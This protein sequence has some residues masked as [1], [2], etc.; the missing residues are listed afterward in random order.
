MGSDGYKNGKPDI[1][2]WLKEIRLG[3]EYR[4]RCAFEQKWERW[5]QYYRGEW[6][7]NILP[8]NV[9]FKMI[10]STV[11]RIYFRNPS[12]SVVPAMPGVENAIF[13]KLLERTDNKLLRIMKTKKHMKRM[14]Q[15]AWMFGTGI[16]KKGFGSQ[17]QSTPE[18]FG[19][20]FPM[21]AASINAKLANHVE[22]NYDIEPNMPW[23]FRTK[24]SHFI[25][26][27]GIDYA[28]EARW[29]CFVIERPLADIKA[30]PTK[31][32]APVTRIDLC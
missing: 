22:Y 7:D 17:Y 28:E 9:F 8:S 10:R 18:V 26:P 31:P 30:D 16:G 24:P 4:K 12:I 25:L 20:T 29:N 21:N 3:L 11:P 15:D 27:A 5:R 6:R 23:F 2:Y 19:S 32:V 13:A 1:G 14:V